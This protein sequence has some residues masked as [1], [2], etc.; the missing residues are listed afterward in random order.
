MSRQTRFALNLLPFVM[1]LAIVLALPRLEQITLPVVRDFVV[2]GMTKEPGFVTLSGYMRKARDCQ[3]VGVQATAMA[4]PDYYDVPIHFLDGGAQNATRP[5]GTQDW[6]PWRITLPVTQA[7]EVRLVSTHR[8][9]PLW[10][11][12]TRLATIPLRAH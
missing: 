10:A 5:T 12:D 4:G 9:H 6:G 1:A 8:C 2:T 11:T 7:D 3:F